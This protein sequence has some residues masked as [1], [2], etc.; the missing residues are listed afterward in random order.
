MAD[1]QID[2]PTRIWILISSATRD[3]HCRYPRFCFFYKSLGI[4]RIVA[5]HLINI[6]RCVMTGVA[7]KNRPDLSV[8]RG[9]PEYRYIIIDGSGAV[10]TNDYTFRCR[11]TPVG[12]YRSSP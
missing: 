8:G 3:E 1:C 10:D 7:E 11:L 6:K 4:T 5:V 2:C 12:G 9:Y